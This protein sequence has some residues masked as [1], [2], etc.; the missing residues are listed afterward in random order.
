MKHKRRYHTR[1]SYLEGPLHGCGLGPCPFTEVACVPTAQR[2]RRGLTQGDSRMAQTDVLATR[3]LTAIPGERTHHGF[4]SLRPMGIIT[5]RTFS[6][7]DPRPIVP[8]LGAEI[9][10]I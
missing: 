2:R 7:F 1:D 6:H 3:G 9:S 5:S 10:G 8:A 4:E